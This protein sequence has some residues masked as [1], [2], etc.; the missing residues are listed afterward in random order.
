MKKVIAS[1]L[2]AYS[3]ASFAYLGTWNDPLKPFDASKNKHKE[4]KIEWVIVPNVQEACDKQSEKM[5]FN[6]MGPATSCAFW[7]G[8]VCKIIT[9]KTPT[10]H[11]VG[12][13]VRHCFQGSWH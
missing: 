6:P 4:V 12:H 3:T 8:A 11:E 1:L 2:V 13:E 7:R 10:M 5:G 9:S